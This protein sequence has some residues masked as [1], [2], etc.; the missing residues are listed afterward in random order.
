MKTA[1]QPA[2]IGAITVIG[3]GLAFTLATLYHGIDTRSIT[4]NWEI[5]IGSMVAAY[6][7]T[8]AIL[9]GTA[10]IRAKAAS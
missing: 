2:A 10:G 5:L 6:A 4:A 9:V 8:A 7:I 3:L 1:V